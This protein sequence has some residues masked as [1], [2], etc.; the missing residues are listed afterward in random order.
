MRKFTKFL[1]IILSIIAIFQIALQMKKSNAATVGDVTYLQRADKG[2]YSIQKW[3]G[4]EWLYVTYSITHYTDKD[5]VSRIAYCIDPDLKGI[6]YISG[7]FEGYDV[8]LKELL[9]DQRL[10]RVYTNGYPYRTP[11]DLG[12]ETEDDAYLA[13]KMASYCI[14]RSYPLDEIKTLY[15]A[16]QDPVAGQKLDDI[17]RRGNKV[18]DAIY[19]LVNIG[20]NGTETMQYNNILKINKVGEFKQDTKDKSY[21]YQEYKVNSTVD[22][23]G[24]KVENISNFPEGS[25]VAN[26][27]GDAKTQFSKG[28]IF[29]IMI[30]KN[31]ILDNISGTINIVGRCKNYPIYYAE[32]TIGEY[33]NYMVCENYS[34]NVKATLSSNINAYKSSLQIKKVDKDTELPIKGVKFTLKY[35]DGKEIGTYETNEKGIIYINGLKQG[36][37]QIEEIETNDKYILDSKIETVNLGYEESKTIKLENELK[38]GSIKIIKVDANNIEVKIPGV[39]FEIYNENNEKM[40]TL[41]TDD[42]GEVTIENLP[43]YMKY[44]IKEV[45]TAKEYELSDKEVTI[46]LNENEIKTLTFKNKKKEVKKEEE[47]KEEKEEEKEDKKE[48]EKETKEEK[49]T[50]PRTGMLDISNY[51][52][53]FSIAGIM[54]N[55]R[56]L[57]KND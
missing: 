11:S 53:G 40:A 46:K 3:T 26:S 28:E 30:P 36:D 27:K 6:G 16:G 23:I 4:S 47:E 35:K 13:T 32:C 50:L 7:E 56:I 49:E 57:R 22:Y 5:G 20:Y 25:F 21:Y 51:L 42:K 18:V 41:I 38:K 55:K 45:E 19:N 48:E 8:K 54:V 44:K 31:K 39:K 14:L 37:I 1:V 15:R 17:Q 34:D 2:F 29:R 33:Q 10:W 43:T 9:S 52:I 24:Y 12:V